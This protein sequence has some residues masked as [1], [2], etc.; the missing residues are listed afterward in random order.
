MLGKIVSSLWKCRTCFQLVLR[1]E[2][3]HEL[4]NA[5]TERSG[6]PLA[7]DGSRLPIEEKDF[8]M[9]VLFLATT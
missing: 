8:W 1:R 5:V 2:A 4:A 3:R 9:Q 7:K 6:N